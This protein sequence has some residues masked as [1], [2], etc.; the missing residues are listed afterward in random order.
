VDARDN[1]AEE[2]PD[3]YD[4]VVVLSQSPAIPNDT[5]SFLPDLDPA[6]R[7]T[8]ISQFLKI[9]STEEGLAILDSVYSWSGMEEVEDSFYDGF[10]QQLEAAGIEFEDLGQ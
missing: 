4:V 10:R 7:A 5:I 8:L 9:A 2:F 3:V 6:V 1:V